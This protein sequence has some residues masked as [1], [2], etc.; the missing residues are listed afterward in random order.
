MG[1]FG[2]FV[3]IAKCVQFIHFACFCQGGFLVRNLV[4]TQTFYASQ[5]HEFSYSNRLRNMNVKNFQSC[6]CIGTILG[7]I[8]FVYN[9]L[10]LMDDLE[11]LPIFILLEC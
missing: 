9:Q 11:S 2:F 4:S 3:T 7:F 5:S 6:E 1:G 10:F 8:R